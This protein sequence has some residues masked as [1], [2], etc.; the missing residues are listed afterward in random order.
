MMKIL[1]L[2]IIASIC[3]SLGASLAGRSKK[4]CFINI[5]LGYIG[6]MLGGWLSRKL[7]IP[8]ILVIYGIPV[9][10]AIIGAAVFVAILGAVS[11]GN[12][13]KK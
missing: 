12:S 13:G 6:A 7:E 4:G 8:D 3:G 10:W 11:G 2:L 1:M 9:I 5:L